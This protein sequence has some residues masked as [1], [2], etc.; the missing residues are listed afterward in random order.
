MHEVSEA[1]R[2][3]LFRT[4]QTETVRLRLRPRVE[5]PG[6]RT[7]ATSWRPFNRFAFQLKIRLNQPLDKTG[8][9][10]MRSAEILY[11]RPEFSLV[12]LA[13]REVA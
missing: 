1:S 10:G 7:I 12:T 3:A 6:L 5:T 11:F 2:F 13:N 4:E 8:L 9:G